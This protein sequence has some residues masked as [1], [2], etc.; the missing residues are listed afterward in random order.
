ME[1]G[2]ISSERCQEEKKKQIWMGQHNIKYPRADKV[3]LITAVVPSHYSQLQQRW[4]RYWNEIPLRAYEKSIR[5]AE[6]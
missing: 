2:C 6:T 3:G 1:M 5:F 4:Q